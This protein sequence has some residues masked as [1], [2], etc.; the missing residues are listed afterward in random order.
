V[1]IRDGESFSKASKDNSR[2]TYR[3]ATHIVKASDPSNLPFLAVNEYYCMRAAGYCGL[4]VPKIALSDNNQ[5]LVVERFDLDENGHYMGFED[6]CVLSGLDTKDKYTK[7]CEHLAKTIN[8]FVAPELRPVAL[9][10]LF[11]SL[12]LSSAIRNGD[13]HLKNFGVL[14]DAS[15]T[16]VRLSP[17]YDI[18][19]TTPYIKGDT[20]ALTIEGSKR[21]PDAEKLVRFGKLHCNLQP[22]RAKN[23]LQEVAESVIKVQSELREHI[24]FDSRISEVGAAILTEWDAGMGD[25][26]LFKR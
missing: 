25:A 12:A 20:F 15:N 17:T 3:G 19:T 7:S 16:E 9:E 1:L 21:F 22:A 4:D 26:C 23:I 6:F 24:K 18:V 10:S 14:Y 2:L 8:S 11:K 13:A 5:M